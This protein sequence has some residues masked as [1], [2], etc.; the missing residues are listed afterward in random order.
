MKRR[1]RRQISVLSFTADGRSI[2]IFLFNRAKCHILLFVLSES[3]H[4]D[5]EKQQILTFLKLKTIKR[6]STEFSVHLPK[7]N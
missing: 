6:L 3:Q 5:K 7:K 1:R 4:Y 2:P